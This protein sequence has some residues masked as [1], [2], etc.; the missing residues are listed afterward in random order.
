MNV[1][2]TSLLATALF[3]GGAIVP[4]HAAEVSLPAD[5]MVTITIV[6][7]CEISA[8]TAVGFGDQLANA[9][10]VVPTADGGVTVQC[11]KGV[12]Y[13]IALNA[14]ENGAGVIADRKMLHANNIDTIDYDLFRTASGG[15]WGE[16]V[17]TNTVTGTGTGIGTAYD[18][19]HTVYA[20]ATIPGDALVGTY[21]DTVTATVIF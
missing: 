12:P 8:V 10:T 3:A 9:G 13:N 21:T 19:F 5:L 4:T 11:T 14:G 18:Q 15:V 17:A 2:K 1:F 7:A 20:E 6:K 16:T